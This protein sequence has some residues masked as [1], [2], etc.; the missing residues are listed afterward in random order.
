MFVKLFT[1]KSPFE[2]M[3]IFEAPHSD[4]QKT[5]TKSFTKHSNI[6]LFGKINARGDLF[7]ESKYTF[8]H[9]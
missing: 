7:F 5:K 2:I 3:H 8:A 1:V 9:C 4:N 6:H